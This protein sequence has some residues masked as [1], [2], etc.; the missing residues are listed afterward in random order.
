M[1]AG[2]LEADNPEDHVFCIS[3][4]IANINVRNRNARFFTDLIGEDTDQEAQELLASLKARVS[5]TMP[6]TNVVSYDIRWTG[7]NGVSALNE[8]H[9]SESRKQLVT[10]EILYELFVPRLLMRHL[11]KG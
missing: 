10:V 6:E 2:V 3:R 4:T 5:D 9:Q 7:E 8:D 11:N 1:D